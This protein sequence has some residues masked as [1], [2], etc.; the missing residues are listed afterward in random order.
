M[1]LYLF[2]LPI[3]KELIKK[4]H[5]VYVI[6]P[7]D[8]G[9]QKLI[10]E[11]LKVVT[12]KIERKSLNPFKELKTIHNIYREI[13]PLNLNVLHTFT[14]KPNIY[15][16]I[17][18]DLAKI[19]VKISTVTGLGSFYISRS[20][21][22]KIVRN[23]MEKLYKSA[24][25]KNS[26]VI[27]Q[28]S[29]DLDYF[30]SKGLVKKEKTHLVRSSGVDM[31]TFNMESLN[32]DEI[33]KLRSLINPDNK[34][35]VLMIAR[36]IKHKGV[37]EYYKAAENLSGKYLFVY[38]GGVDHGNP[39]SMDEGF[40]NSPHVK[41][42]GERW[43]VHNIIAISDLFVLPSYREGVPR[44]LLEAS[45][46]KKPLITTD[47]VGCREVVRDGYNGFLTPLKEST[48]LTKKIEEVLENEALAEK[49]GNNAYNLCKEE[50]S[51]EKIVK[52]YIAYYEK[53]I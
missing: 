5:D 2:R 38:V 42:L 18:G 25:K 14:A 16:A 8:D 53:F 43:D 28:N 27:F 46:M 30:I 36:A 40:M 50:F 49:F 31:K 26:G 22:A 3:I 41:Y 45:A 10:D 1:N 15:G 48:I 47:S 21:K 34:K 13:K 19:P 6:T 32:E 35:M 52:E 23:A 4:G 7:K 9:T 12:Y 39:A 17:A 33:Q 20:T 44:T 29:D 11:N 24:F 51:S 37:R